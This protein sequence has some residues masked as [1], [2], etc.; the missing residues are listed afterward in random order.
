MQMF[1]ND[2]VKGL[3]VICGGVSGQL[4][5]IDIDT[6]YD[7][8]G[9]LFEDFMVEVQQADASLASKLLIATTI[10]GGYHIYYRCENV[11]GNQK[12]ASRPTTV[13]AKG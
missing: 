9:K 7:L 2:R 3:G 1:N 8:S 5:V 11:G 4:E 13:G 10:N 6:K 12:L